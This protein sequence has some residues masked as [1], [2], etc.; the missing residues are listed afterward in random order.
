MEGRF[1]RI[2][3]TRTLKTFQAAPRTGSFK[4]AASKLCLTPSAV[5][6]RIKALEEDLGVALFHRGPRELTLT[7]AGSAYLADVDAAFHQLD[8]ATGTLRSRFGRPSLHVRVPPF[9]VSE[10]LLPRLAN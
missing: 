3:S 5:S 8:A 7:E 10:F 4:H 1:M 2:P 6:Y 9:F